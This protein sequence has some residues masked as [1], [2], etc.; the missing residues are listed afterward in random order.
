MVTMIKDI[1]LTIIIM[2][3]EF[4][5]TAL[6]DGLS[7]ESEWQ[8]VSR[9]LFSIQAKLNNA[10][11]WVILAHPPISNSSRPLTKPLG[12]VLSTSV[13]MGVIPVVTNVLMLTLCSKVFF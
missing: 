6:A 8:Q 11:V 1:S 2:H 3:C 7:L 4:F 13:T 9:T 10:A 12:I 5:T